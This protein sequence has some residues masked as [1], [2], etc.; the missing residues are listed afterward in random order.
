MVR[1]I[2]ADTKPLI[3][4][5]IL[6]TAGDLLERQQSELV[7][8]AAREAGK[9]LP[10][11]L[12]EVREAVDYCRYYAQLL[13][14][15]FGTGMDL[16]GTTGES[17]RLNLHGRGLFVC[18][19]P[20]NFPIAIFSGQVA[21]ALAA[22]NGVIAKPASLTPLV[23]FRIV[24]LFHEAGVPVQSLQYIPG[25]SAELGEMLV[26]D[27]RVAGVSFTGSSETARSINQAMAARPGPIIPLIAETGGMNAM[28]VD[29]SAL[30]EQAVSDIVESAFNSAGQ[31]CSALRILLVQQEIA[32]RIIEMLSG[33]M[34]ELVIGDP[35]KLATDI[36]PV[37]DA[38]SRSKLQAHIERL[39]TNS[40]LLS[41][42]KPAGECARGVFFAPHLLEIDNPS[43]LTS[44]VFGPVL[45]LIRYPA[46]RLEQ[47]LSAIKA[48]G[49]ALT[50][51]I[52]SRVEA[53]IGSIQQQLPVGNTYINRNMIGAVVGVQPFGGEG[54]SG[55]GPKAGGP[56]TLLRYAT[57]RTVTVNTAAVGGNVSLLA[58]DE[59]S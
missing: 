26:G 41:T 10:D 2:W 53:T 23:G 18:I 37:I 56:Y 30:A 49:Y 16:P 54:L 14:S 38:A 28:I 17:N 43:L 22:G 51:G 34:Q 40:E 46:N 7:A 19:S 32:P 8:L 42:A 20:W 21:A 29:S 52:H 11:A 55:T 35:L 39:G 58:L 12:D 57:E 9:T 15:G 25:P 31:R 27:A 48:T 59:Q 47:I 3:R 13:R 50:L 4:A 24:K 45:H 36:G 5:Q 1:S 6:E 44:E 33:A